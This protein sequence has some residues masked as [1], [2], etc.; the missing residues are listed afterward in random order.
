MHTNFFKILHNKETATRKLENLLPERSL[1]QMRMT[2]NDLFA[3]VLFFIHTHIAKG[4]D[5]FMN[6]FFYKLLLISVLKAF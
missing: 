1:V 4:C 5:I 6:H 3:L 2:E